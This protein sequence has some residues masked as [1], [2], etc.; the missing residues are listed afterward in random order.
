MAIVTIREHVYVDHPAGALPR[1]KRLATFKRVG[2]L[3]DKQKRHVKFYKIEGSRIVLPRGL[4][5]KIQSLLPAVQIIDQRLT[6]KPVEFGFRMHL[7]D[8][9]QAAVDAIVRQGGGVVVSPPGSGKTIMLLGAIA[10][11]QQPTLFLVHTLR[12]VQQTRDKARQALTL[13]RDGLG[14]V[15]DSAKQYGSHLTIATIQTLAKKPRY[16]REL[17]AQVGT[18]IVDEAH[19]SPAESFQKVVNSFPARWRAGASATPDR[20]DGLGGMVTAIMGPRV[21]IARRTLRER[22]VILDPAIYMVYTPWIAPVD[23]SYAE[24]ELARAL[25]GPRNAMIAR[26]VWLARKRRQRVLVLVERERHAGLLAKILNHAGIAAYA[27]TGKTPTYLQDVRFK[28]M[29]QGKAVAVAT[30]LANEGLDWPSLDCLVVATP[31]R[32]GTVLEQRTGR[33]ARTAQGKTL[34]TVYDL[35]DAESPTYMAQTT[36]RLAKYQEMGYRVRRFRWPGKS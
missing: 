7:R 21:V 27:V 25:D 12:L 4:Q 3:R 6:V 34:A 26:L 5:T 33:I 9:Q 18:V 11:W 31:G 36:A 35:V 23:A 10:A 14:I 24:T 16:V 2:R 1:L 8:Y 19:H 17:A 13:P 15:A 30:K 32:S 29:E 28:A 22:G 20:E